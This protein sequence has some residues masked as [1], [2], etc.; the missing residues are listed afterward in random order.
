[1]T[2]RNA[3]QE[4]L[5]QSMSVWWRTFLRDSGLAKKDMSEKPPDVQTVLRKVKRLSMMK[6]AAEAAALEK[7][8]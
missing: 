2:N 6:D 8:L 5:K 7:R 3:P 1:M 4:S